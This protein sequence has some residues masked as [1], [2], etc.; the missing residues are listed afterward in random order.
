V[1][2]L[3]LYLRTLSRNKKMVNLKSHL[4]LTNIHTNLNYDDLDKATNIRDFME[5]IKDTIYYKP[6]VPFLDEEPAQMIFHMEMVLD[7]FYFD[8]LYISATKLKKKDRDIMLELLGI[9]ID[10]LNI[11]W[12]FR[13]RRFF[14]ISSEELFNFTLI[15]G[16][17]YDEKTLKNLC[18]M[19]LEDFRNLISKGDYKDL[20]QDKE[21]MMERAMERHIYN[22]L[23]E[24][25]KKSSLSIALPIIFLFKFEYE[26]RDLFTIIEGVHYHF[27]DIGELL[28]REIGRDQKWP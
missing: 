6:L 17:R 5:G 26:M 25:T 23:D 18:Y 11:Q 1:E 2:N 22:M 12:I 3:K 13:G 10:I 16:R 8:K 20:F 24:Y 9:N 28:I 4:I 27:E 15:H 14:D 21:Y 19:E 7:K